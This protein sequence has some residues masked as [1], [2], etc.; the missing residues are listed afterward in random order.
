MMKARYIVAER[1]CFVACT[2]SC[3]A[4]SLWLRATAVAKEEAILASDKENVQI[5]IYGVL[6][7]N[8]KN[9]IQ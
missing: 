5:N 6:Y 8:D 2:S 9:K 1:K 3:G 7:K 4:H